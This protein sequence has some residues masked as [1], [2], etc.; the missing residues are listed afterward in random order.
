MAAGDMNDFHQ[1]LTSL[2]STDNNVRQTAE[3]Y[4]I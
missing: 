3:V 1:I 2:L 4:T